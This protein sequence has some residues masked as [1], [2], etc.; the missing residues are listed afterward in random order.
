MNTSIK[1]E[2]LR[3]SWSSSKIDKSS[4][5]SNVERTSLASQFTSSRRKLSTV[6]SKTTPSWHTGASISE[7]YSN[8]SKCVISKKLSMNMNS[9]S[10]R[11][12]ITSGKLVSTFSRTISWRNLTIPMGRSGSS[13]SSTSIKEFG[14]NSE[15][16][17]SINSLWCTTISQTWLIYSTNP[18]GFHIA[19]L[20]YAWL[21]TWGSK[22]CVCVIYL[23]QKLIRVKFTICTIKLTI[24]KTCPK[25][26]SICLCSRKL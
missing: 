23:F 11:K 4:K 5:N 15:A 16:N 9:S 14:S 7:L 26:R 1:F 3:T 6:R 2:R 10:T 13:R 25:S 21:I 8:S 18:I 20:I 19:Y 22:L 24:C 12:F 17:N